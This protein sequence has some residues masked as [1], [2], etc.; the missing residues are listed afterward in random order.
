MVRGPYDRCDV[1]GRPMAMA[2]SQRS[3]V[4]Q[5]KR[6][7]YRM[8]WGNFSGFLLRWER[9]HNYQNIRNGHRIYAIFC[10]AHICGHARKP[11][12]CNDNFHDL[13]QP[14]SMTIMNVCEVHAHRIV[15]SRSAWATRC[16][17]GA[18]ATQ[19]RPAASQRSFRQWWHGLRRCRADSPV[20]HRAGV[21]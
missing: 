6:A 11:P 1:R 9:R 20:R 3:N 5:R 21:G 16:K 18:W 4:R 13:S 7:G 19:V 15:S 17:H 2:R 8:N 10:T 12:F 14:P